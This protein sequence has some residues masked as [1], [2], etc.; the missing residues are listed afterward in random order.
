MCTGIKVEFVILGIIFFFYE[1]FKLQYSNL[2]IYSYH[3]LNLN[4]S[5][6]KIVRVYNLRFYHMMM[7]SNF[8]FKVIL[9]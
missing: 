6:E 7:S 4:K 3:K 2:I 5:D 9:L 8:I 1:Y